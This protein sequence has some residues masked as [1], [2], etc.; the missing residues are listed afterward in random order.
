LRVI[1]YF[2]AIVMGLVQGVTELF[3]VSSLAQAVILPTVFGWDN[4]AQAQSQPESFFLAFLVGLHVQRAFF[5]GQAPSK[6]L[7]PCELLSEESPQP[8]ERAGAGAQV[9]HHDSARAEIV[10]RRDPLHLHR[11]QSLARTDRIAVVGNSVGI[12][13]R[14]FRGGVLEDFYGGSSRQLQAVAGGGEEGL[15]EGAAAQNTQAG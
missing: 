13:R 9:H 2:Q 1:T 6:E 11:R 8:G 3:P 15:F 5:S 10:R 7:R 12:G 14:S 4:L